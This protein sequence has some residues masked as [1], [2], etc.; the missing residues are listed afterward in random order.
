MKKYLC[1]IGILLAFSFL[2]SCKS[3]SSAAVAA[4]AAAAVVTAITASEQA[5]APKSPRWAAELPPEGMIWGIGIALGEKQGDA[6][7]TAERRG[8]VSIGRTL[9]AY[10][11]DVFAEY[12]A[13]AVNGARMSRDVLEDINGKI[14]Q[15]PFDEAKAVLRWKAPDGAWWYRVEY[16]TADARAFLAGIF[17]E[18]ETLFPTFDGATAMQCLETRFG[19]V[20]V[21]SQT[22]TDQ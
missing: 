7:R 20:D 4:T 1:I 22:D 10:I 2:F 15:A 18:E 8:K 16:K 21:P 13:Y 3:S 19:G 9:I 14:T 12:D 11:H 6:I 5:A 17:D